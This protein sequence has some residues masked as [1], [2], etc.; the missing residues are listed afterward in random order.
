MGLQQ[1]IFEEGELVQLKSGSP[2][3][4][5]INPE[6]YE[7]GGGR[8]VG[9]YHTVTATWMPT[10]LIISAIPTE[11]IE[12]VPDYASASVGTAQ[13]DPWSPR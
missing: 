10:G 12:L 9:R 7:H 13:R 11:A 1:R 8:K 3:M 2:R 4:V 5:V 6:A